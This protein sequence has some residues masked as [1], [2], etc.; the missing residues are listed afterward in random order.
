MDD[1]TIKEII[2]EELKKLAGLTWK[3]RLG[4]I[5]DYYKPLMVIILLI[6]GVI[7]VIVSIY[8]NKQINH[9]FQA[10]LI[11]CDS[12]QT[13]ADEMLAEFTD[14]I[15][16]IEALD[17]ITIDTSISYEQDDMSQYGMA[18][19]MK[20]MALIAAGEVDLMIADETVYENYL[21]AGG[22]LDLNEVFS[23]EELT[24]WQD[25]LVEGTNA[26]DGT[27]G[28]FG[29]KLTDSPVLGRYPA[30]PEED[31]YAMFVASGTHTDL[32]AEF[33]DYLLGL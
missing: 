25:Y 24:R 3:Q 28:I 6:I 14:Y 1:K 4:Y 10:Y 8:H 16:G 13:D 17:E 21:T 29:V 9:I 32:S 22:L 5:W 33:L 23:G 2:R 15:G 27:T 11:N 12:Y 31:C 18:S 19:Q 7:S 26:E 20:I 30:Y